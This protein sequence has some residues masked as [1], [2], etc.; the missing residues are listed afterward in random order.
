MSCLQCDAVPRPQVVDEQ[1]P[2]ALPLPLRHTLSLSLTCAE[3]CSWSPKQEGAGGQ[4]CE[5]CGCH[6]LIQ[7]GF[8]LGGS[9]GERGWGWRVGP[10]KYFRPLPWLGIQVQAWARVCTAGSL[11]QALGRRPSSTPSSGCRAPR[12]P[13]TPRSLAWAGVSLKPELSAS[14]ALFQESPD[15]GAGWGS[16]AP[17]VG[18]RHK[19][20]NPLLITH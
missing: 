7:P 6:D 5:G 10:S 19:K 11:L 4:A 12:P 17:L 16:E 18:P 14:R 20:P 13:G 2:W 1:W 3:S 8:S 15:P 9:G